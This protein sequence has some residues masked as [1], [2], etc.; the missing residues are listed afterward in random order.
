MPAPTSS[1]TLPASPPGSAPAGGGRRL[2]PPWTPRRVIAWIAAAGSL[3]LVVVAALQVGVEPDRL[4]DGWQDMGNLLERMTPI[5]A[6]N[7]A[8]LAKPLLDTLMMAVAGTALAVVASVPLAFLAAANTSPHPAARAVARAVILGA[9]SIPDLIYALIFV[10]VLG[11]GILPGVLAIA[12]Y[13]T[14]MV[15][16][17]F[18]DA[19]EETDP[20]TSQALKAVGARRLQIITTGVLPQVSPSLVSVSLY[21]LDMNVT[22]S[23]VLGFVGAGGI[24]FELYTTLRT[25]Q[26]QKGLGI[27]LIIIALVITVERLSAV[28]RSRLTT[29]HDSPS[30]GGPTSRGQRRLSAPWTRTRVL[31]QIAII[32]AGAVII[33]SFAGL[34]ISPLTLAAAVPALFVGLADFWPPDFAS[35]ADLLPAAMTETLSIAITATAMATLLSVPIAAFAARTI[36]PHPALY[37]AARML[38]VLCRG[39]PPLLLALIFVSA[40]GLGPF[41]GAIALGLATIGMTAKLMAD[42]IEHLDSGPATALRAVGATRPQQ[43]AAAVIPQ[44]A[45]SFVSTVLFTLDSTIRSSTIVGVVGAGGIGFITYQSVHT[46]QFQTTTAVLIVIFTTVFCVERAADTIRKRIL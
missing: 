19:I 20:G 35:V 8:Q 3:G 7:L 29:H 13:S 9:R 22:A 39:L 38:I 42:A 28:V 18:A 30:A 17:L 14:G 12:V 6:P 37:H 25:L 10:R 32:V 44:V 15:G 31:R 23:A 21:R 2:S 33:A 36:A 43:N 1:A 41:A 5:E 40:F 45:P 24:G 11:V 4:I 26:Y 46:L 34:E 27:A 16:K